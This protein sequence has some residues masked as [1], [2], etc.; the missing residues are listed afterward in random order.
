MLR[1]G[2]R[3][4][5]NERVTTHDEECYIYDRGTGAARR[6]AGRGQGFKPG[7]SRSRTLRTVV[8]DLH[9]GAR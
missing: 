5:S 9:F 1:N 7:A 8:H 4:W 6:G 2:V 3:R